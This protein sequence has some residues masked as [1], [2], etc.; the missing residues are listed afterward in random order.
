MSNVNL[1]GQAVVN[2][3]SIK[4]SRLPG[5]QIR[6]KNFEGIR[7]NDGKR[8]FTVVIDNESGKR[9]EE[10]GWTCVSWKP[11]IWNDPES[12]LVPCFRVKI[13]SYLPV[14]Y[15]VASDGSR[16][17]VA[18]EQIDIDHL[19]KRDIDWISFYA[20]ASDTDS[21][22]KHYHTAYLREIS[23]KFKASPFAEEFGEI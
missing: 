15:Y 17:E 1:P 14:V 6:F 7:W 16:T 20:T 23:I 4:L 12:E 10:L 11:S 8:D 22:G 5:R 2:E 13:G 21:M 19:D 3:Y 9:A 18:F